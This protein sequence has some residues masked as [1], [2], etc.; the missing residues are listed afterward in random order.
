[1]RFPFEKVTP[2]EVHEWLQVFATSRGTT[3]ELF[4]LTALT[5]TSALIGKT[6]MEVFHS[7][8]EKGNLFLVAVAP[9]GAGK[10][11]ACHHGCIDPIVQHLEPKLDKSIV[12]DE[13]SVNGLFNHF[14]SSDSVPILCIDEAYSFLSKI[15]SS[16]KSAVQVNLTMERLC[17]CF[18]GDCWYVLKG[19]KGKR[20]GVSSARASLIAFTTP[21]QFLERVWPKIV[22]AENGLAERIV[23]LPEEGPKRPRE[24]GRSQPTAGGRLLSEVNQGCAG[25]NSH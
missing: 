25:A 5:S 23:F 3:R 2:T 12:L 17:K 13:T 9:S 11:P 15:S 7:Y 24:D 16:S 8:E 21:R 19:N 20:T 1:M 4:L 14:V 6:T 10:S 18:D 22:E